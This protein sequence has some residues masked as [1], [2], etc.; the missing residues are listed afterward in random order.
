MI[1]AVEVPYSP[2]EEAELAA[3]L[4]AA[5]RLAADP[6]LP[7]RGVLGRVPADAVARHLDRAVQVVEETGWAQGLMRGEDGGVCLLQALELAA[8]GGHIGSY[9]SSSTYV[10]GTYLDVMVHAITG[11]PGWY[12]GWNDEPGRTRGEALD[13]LKDAAAFARSH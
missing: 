7:Y 4:D 3:R 6:L 8:D 1:D 9:E 10:A 11:R 2:V 5:A 13:L 12:L